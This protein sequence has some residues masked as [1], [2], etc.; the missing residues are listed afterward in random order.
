MSFKRASRSFFKSEKLL[1]RASREIERRESIKR[2]STELKRDEETNNL[3]T[4]LFYSSL[5]S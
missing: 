3:D 1:Q 4:R 5:N 2:A